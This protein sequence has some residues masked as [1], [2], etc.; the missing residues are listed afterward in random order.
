MAMTKTRMGGFDQQ[1]QHLNDNDPVVDWMGE[2]RTHDNAVGMFCH[3][4]LCANISSSYVLGGGDER[5]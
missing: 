3:P 2:E 5:L 1:Q 4:P